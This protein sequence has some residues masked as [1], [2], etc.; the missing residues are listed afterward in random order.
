MKPPYKSEPIPVVEEID[1]GDDKY[2]DSGLWPLLFS[3]KFDLMVKGVG[4][5]GDFG[6]YVFQSALEDFCQCRHIKHLLLRYA[7][8]IE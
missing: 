7:I 3:M 6:R 2:R 8:Y 1:Y 5:Y 4:L